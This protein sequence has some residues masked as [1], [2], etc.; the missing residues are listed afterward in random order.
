MS[1][2][3]F[4]DSDA[5]IYRSVGGFDCCG[6]SITER[7]KLET[8]WTDMFGIVHEYE[9]APAIF[10]TPRELLDHVADHRARGDWVS[11]DVDARI[12]E[13]FPDLD[14]DASETEE[15]RKERMEKTREYLKNFHNKLDNE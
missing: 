12:A 11:Y 10:K 8:P 9:A 2:C 7:T 5:Y 4:S 15:E 14:V 6:C 1:Y 3:R 13:E